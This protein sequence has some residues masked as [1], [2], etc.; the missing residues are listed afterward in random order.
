[1]PLGF[2]VSTTGSP[3]TLSNDAGS[4][5]EECVEEA[6][7]ELESI[8]D[9]EYEARRSALRTSAMVS[10]SDGRQHSKGKE[11]TASGA[12]TMNDGSA[13]QEAFSES[14]DSASFYSS[15]YT[16]HGCRLRG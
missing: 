10:E 13:F 14:D 6:R 9:D 2:F 1:M 5:F 11:S 7:P 3:P 16:G 12:A 8:W 4:G 15:R